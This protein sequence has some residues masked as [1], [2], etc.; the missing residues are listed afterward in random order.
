MVVELPVG[1]V[2]WMSNQMKIREEHRELEQHPDLPRIMNRTL[3]AD[4]LPQLLLSPIKVL[5]LDP[6]SCDVAISGP[7]IC[8]EDIWASR[9]S[10]QHYSMQQPGCRHE[11]CIEQHAPLI[12][13]PINSFPL[14]PNLQF[15]ICLFE[16]LLMFVQYGEE[17]HVVVN[18]A[19]E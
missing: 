9:L 5:N 15:L 18:G 19:L 6:V 16:Y 13:E 14:V 12:R 11:R 8:G 3:L 17:R 7:I 4:A 10:L 2:Q 1:R